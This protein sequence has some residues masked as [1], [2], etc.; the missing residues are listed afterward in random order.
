M[1]AAHVRRG[2]VAGLLAG[3]LAGIVGMVVAGPS[4]DAAIAIEEAA[5]GIAGGHEDEEAAIT[6]SQQRAGLVVG[7]TLLGVG[8]G[9]LFGLATAWA[10]GRVQGSAWQRAVKL[11]AVLTASA[12]ILPWLAYAPN[13]P[14]VGDPDT[15]ATRSALYLGTI[16]LGLLLSGF[17]WS[18]LRALADRGVPPAIRQAGV[19][20]GIILVAGALLSVLPGADGAGVFPADLLW[21]FRLSSLATQVTLYAGIAV[22]AGLLSPRTATDPSAGDVSAP[23]AP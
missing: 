14:A 23:A 13:P 8:V 19:G 11:G 17:G 7:S 9:A 22:I 2:V 12:A 6:R 16:V 18:S 20:V 3:L 15:V 10:V 5:A 21:R 1:I 4:V